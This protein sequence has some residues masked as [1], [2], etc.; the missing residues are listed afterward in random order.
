[1]NRN[2][3]YHFQTETFKGQF[4]ILLFSPCHFDQQYPD[5][6]PSTEQ[7]EQ[8]PSWPPVDT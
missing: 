7:D 1:M 2:D 8:N 5:G 3:M 4:S 6:G